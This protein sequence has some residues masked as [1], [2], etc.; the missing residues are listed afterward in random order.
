MYYQTKLAQKLWRLRNCTHNNDSHVFSPI[1]TVSFILSVYTVSRVF[2][3]NNTNGLSVVVFRI[4]SLWEWKTKLT[5]LI[6]DCHWHT[7]EEPKELFQ[8]M[9]TRNVLALLQ[10]THL[11]QLRLS[12]AAYQSFCQCIVKSS[13]NK[14][15]CSLTNLALVIEAP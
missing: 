2:Y 12:W 11:W 7:L 5:R 4:N 13:N 10:R 8:T 14:P 3:R 1:I 15:V 9:V 6:V